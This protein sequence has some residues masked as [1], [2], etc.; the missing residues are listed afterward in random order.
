MTN[1]IFRSRKVTQQQRSLRLSTDP[2]LLRL[3]QNMAPLKVAPRPSLQL[4]LTAL[5]SLLE[6]RLT[7]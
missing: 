6:E 3:P 5:A 1:F 7:T 2:P 4:I